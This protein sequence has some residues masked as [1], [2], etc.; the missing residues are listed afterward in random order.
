MSEN[1]FQTDQERFWA[2]E[3][4]DDYVA[5]NIGPELIAAKTARFVKILERTGRIDNVL[6]LGGML[7]STFGPS[8]I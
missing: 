2:E 1:T 3:F 5:R 6:E 7:D 4:G 8:S